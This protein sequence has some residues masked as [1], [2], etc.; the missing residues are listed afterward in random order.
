[1]KLLLLLLTVS[2]FSCS[3]EKYSV[4]NLR[5]NSGSDTCSHIAVYGGADSTLHIF[6]Q[7]RIVPVLAKCNPGAEVNTFYVVL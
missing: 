2:G 4:M 7:K 1:M 6:F 3:A 5:A